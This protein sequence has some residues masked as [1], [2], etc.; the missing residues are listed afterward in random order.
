MIKVFLKPIFTECYLLFVLP[1][2][3]R[4]AASSN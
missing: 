4:V 1:S 2:K 3:L